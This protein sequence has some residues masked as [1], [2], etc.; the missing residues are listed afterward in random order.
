MKETADFYWKV[1]VSRNG[2]N[3]AN[4]NNKYIWTVVFIITKIIIL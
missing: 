3:L 1:G 4:I 2:M